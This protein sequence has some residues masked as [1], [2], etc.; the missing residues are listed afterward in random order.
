M[1]KKK[2][3]EK[4]REDQSTTVNNKSYNTT[5]N[6]SQYNQESQI[7]RPIEQSITSKIRGNGVL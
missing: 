3:I 2:S 1:N 5:N 4:A 6:P 7:D